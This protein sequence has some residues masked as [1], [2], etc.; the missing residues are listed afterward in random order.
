MGEI[1]PPNEITENKNSE[2]ERNAHDSNLGKHHRLESSIVPA[3]K[4]GSRVVEP[5]GKT[6]RR[7][8]SVKD[9][10]AGP[11]YVRK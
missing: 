1:R 8:L 9:A 7:L 2:H 6:C 3:I 11:S 4:N 5:N 10:K